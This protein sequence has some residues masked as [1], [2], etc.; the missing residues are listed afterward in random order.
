[1]KEVRSTLAI[2]IADIETQVFFSKAARVRFDFGIKGRR[3][4]ASAAASIHDQPV[5]PQCG[6]GRHGAR[7]ATHCSNYAAFPYRYEPRL[8]AAWLFQFTLELNIGRLRQ[9]VR[10]IDLR[11]EAQ[12]DLD[13]GNFNAANE[14]RTVGVNNHDIRSV[15][16]LNLVFRMHRRSS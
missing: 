12:N 3:N 14:R 16:V 6:W 9:V 4:F 5:R 2:D 8:S 10:R 15:G 1:M 7:A 13:V 11:D